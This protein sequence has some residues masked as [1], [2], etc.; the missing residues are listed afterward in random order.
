[1]IELCPFEGTESADWFGVKAGNRHGHDVTACWYV[2]A[3]MTHDA[4]AL[5]PMAERFTR[6]DWVRRINLMADSVGGRPGDLVPIDA[7]ELL[8]Q[9]TASVGGMPAGDLGDPGWQERFESLVADL[10]ASPMHLVGRLMTKQELLRSLRTRML[11]TA[12]IDAKPE[13]TAEPVAAPV[14]IAGPAR[15]GTSIL[16]ELLDLHPDLRAPIGAEALHPVPLPESG[17]A[18]PTELGECEQE[19]WADIQPEFI[20]MH[21]FRADLPVECITLTQGSF[22]G[23]HWSMIAPLQGWFP[24]LAVNYSY[25]RQILQVL[26]HGT[27]GTQWVLKTPGHLFVLPQLFEAFGDA[28]VVQTHRDPARTMASTASITAMV[29]WMRFS[30]VDV[31]GNAQFVHDAFAFALNDSVNLRTTGAVPDERFVDINYTQ[32]VSDPVAALGPAF[33]QMG[34]PLTDA[35]AA[36]VRDYLAHK[37]KGKYGAHRYQPED[38]GL[39]TDGIRA[40][41]AQYIEHFGLDP[42]G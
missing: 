15:S 19:F 12:A 8:K 31:G 6:P 29:H 5:A 32:L 7:G 39:T 20:A 23:F 9:A 28:W 11:L 33:E 17:L 30:E 4:V 26:Q 24:D 21:E 36:A 10:D 3:R 2:A 34:V 16:F 42:E 22:A 14:I 40:A 25:E 27:V 37:P 38:W 13:I 1:M 41:T 18:D 35:Y